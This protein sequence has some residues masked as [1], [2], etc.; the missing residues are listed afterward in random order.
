MLE[1]ARRAFGTELVPLEADFFAELGGHSL[2]AARFVSF[3]R[4]TPALATIRLQDVYEARNLRAHRRSGSR[5]DARRT[6]S[7]S[8]SPSR[9]RPC[10]AASF[11]ASR[12]RR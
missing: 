5:R 7:R 1:A 12:K 11:A 3:V 9:R 8:I 4:E 6:P 2:I 10:C